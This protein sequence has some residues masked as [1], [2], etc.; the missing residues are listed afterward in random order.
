[1]NIQ[2]AL[3]LAKIL[4]NEAQILLSKVLNVDKSYLIAWPEKMLTDA[5]L[6]Q[7]N[8]D[9]ARREAGEPIAYI[10]GEKEFYSLKLKVTADVLIPRP[11]TELL[12]DLTQEKL[13][14]VASPRVL[15]LGT[16]SGAV[17]IALA[18]NQA[19]WDITAL[20]ES[21]AALGVAQYNAKQHDCTQIRWR[22]SDWFEGL[23]S[24]TFDVIVSNPPYIDPED[25]HLSDGD[26]RFEPDTALVSA[27]Q[28]YA[29]L[30]QIISSAPKYLSTGGWLLL[31]HGYQQGQKVQHLL[32]KVGFCEIF[33]Q[34]DLAGHP[35]VSY[36]RWLP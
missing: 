18:F 19:S 17:A 27:E 11:E 1:M 24:E 3:K 9:C 5:Q 33:T 10:L 14:D 16:G 31:E 2:E 21:E 15:E 12:V 35:R 29:D 22:Q 8:D 4:A 7:F 6:K 28:G 36:G 32:Q 26:V 30:K 13:N 23:Q 20:D 34:N 25:P